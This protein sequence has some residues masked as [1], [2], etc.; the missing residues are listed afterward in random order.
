M[1]RLILLSTVW[2]AFGAGATAQAT[3]QEEAARPQAAAN[4]QAFVK[5]L[6]KGLFTENAKIRYSLSEALRTMGNQ[7]V[8]ELNRLKRAT[9]NPHHAAFVNRI[10]QRIKPD[11]KMSKEE[12]DRRSMMSMMGF[13]QSLDIDRLAMEVA[14]TFEQMAKVEPILSKTQKNLSALWDEFRK[15]NAW[16][17]RDAWGVLRDE[18][19]NAV[20]EAV[21]NLR[22][23]VGGKQA[24]QLKKLINRYANPMGNRGRGGRGGGRGDRRGGGRRERP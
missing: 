1:K 7:A 13:Q 12:R 4:A 6:T 20:D 10:I 3:A 19:K 18:Q 8:P 22:K 11:K 17:D 15:A 16:R 24:L 5:I 2:L 23:H 9:K 14:L 21:A